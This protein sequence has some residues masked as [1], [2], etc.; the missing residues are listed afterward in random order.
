MAAG[1]NLQRLG[2]LLLEEGL[3]TTEEVNRSVDE[4]GKKQHPAARLLATC[5]H[6]KREE[7]VAVLAKNFEIPKIDLAATPCN[8]E[9]VALVPEA[10]ARKHEIMPVER[11]GQILVIARQNYFNRAAIVELKK[12]TGLKIAVLQADE[13]QV[14]AAIDQH[15]T[16]Q[17]AAAPAAAAAAAAASPAPAGA[18]ATRT[19]TRPMTPVAPVP[20]VPVRETLA[21][22]NPTGPVRGQSYPY[23]SIREVAAPPPAPAPALAPAPPP[24]ELVLPEPD[25]PAWQGPPVSDKMAAAAPAS[26]IE[27]DP[28]AGNDLEAMP[29]EVVPTEAA[30]PEHPLLTPHFPWPATQIPAL[31]PPG[32]RARALHIA[33][34]RDDTLVAQ[35]AMKEEIVREWERLYL[36]GSPLP[37]IRIAK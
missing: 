36:T 3:I 5:G 34:T 16:G 24:S 1:D 14:Q 13:T 18:T 37:A 32:Q 31:Q 6:V 25:L 15:Y 17:A 28:F 12:I 19:P 20:P 2:E 30:A 33:W 4:S 35:K 7:L 22:A 23:V 9:A 27:A 29:V 21:S 10:T 8:P 11:F 26:P